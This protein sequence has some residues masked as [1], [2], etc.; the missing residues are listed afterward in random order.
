M[1]A[2]RSQNVVLPTGV[3]SATV[4]FDKGKIVHV[5]EESSSESLD[6]EILEIGS[7]A[8]LPGII[9]THVHINEPG[10]TEWEGFK[11]A[12]HAAAAGGITT[13]ID[14][15]LNCIP[16]TTTTL[17]LLEKL[18]ALKGKLWV[19]CGLHGGVVPGNSDELLPM[20]N[21][22]VRSFKAF[23]IDSGIEEFK[24]CSEGDLSKAMPILAEANIPLLVHAELGE[25]LRE[26]RD[27][28]AYK[29]F[30]NSRPAQMEVEAIRKIIALA[31]KYNS[32]IHIVHLSAAEALPEIKKAKEQGVK[33]TA[34]TCP[35][36]LV[37]AAEGIPDGDG[38]YKCAPPIRGS[39]NRDLLWQ[40][41]RDGVI[42]FIVSDH[43]PC[44]PRLKRLEEENLKLAW[45]GISSLQFGLSLI[46]TAL[47]QRGMTLN[48]LC[49]W[50][51]QR[52]SKLVGLDQRKGKIATGFDADFV[53][54]DPEKEQTILCENIMHRHKITPY[55]GQKVFGQVQ[56]TFLR[57]EKIFGLSNEAMVFSDRPQGEVI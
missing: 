36:Y 2:I 53:I 5:L 7:L 14:M 45:G 20:I 30:L 29:S 57:G 42:D 21:K 12:T 33:I 9:D 16:V 54:M 6:C 28:K 3:K 17:A 40:G 24:C 11:S 35:H 22:G 46:W 41:L 13:V 48:E 55:E 51:C 37:L 23:M 43:S 39:K 15:P 19:D 49:L 18:K 38:R 50:M 52:P 56:A 10:R 47:R 25:F 8:L 4:V 44:L 34:E 27:D 1:K 26:Q 32:W 31:K